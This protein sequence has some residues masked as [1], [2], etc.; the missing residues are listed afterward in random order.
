VRSAMVFFP[1]TRNDTW[2]CKA[3][4]FL[5]GGYNLVSQGPPRRLHCFVMFRPPYCL[6]DFASHFILAH[7]MK[8]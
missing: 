2:A 3:T 7:V 6:V 4:G 5:I 1:I 8:P